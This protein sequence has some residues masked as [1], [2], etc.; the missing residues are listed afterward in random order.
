MQHFLQVNLDAWGPGWTRLTNSRSNIITLQELPSTLRRRVSRL[1]YKWHEA[2]FKEIIYD[3]AHKI[4]FK[5]D[6][7]YRSAKQ[8][9]MQKSQIETL[10]LIGWWMDYT[11]RRE[12]AL[13][14]LTRRTQAAWLCPECNET[15]EAKRI[16]CLNHKCPSWDKLYKCTGDPVFRPS[17]KPSNT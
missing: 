17:P 2:D 16:A 12:Y 4:Q 3:A 7:T 13:Q 8:L 9:R 6:G 5:V 15:V 1:F 14:T 10:Q 11:R